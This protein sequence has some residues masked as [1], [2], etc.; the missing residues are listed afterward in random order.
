MKFINDSTGFAIH[1]KFV[2]YKTSDSGKI[3]EKIPRDNQF[4]DAGASHNDL[5][6]INNNQFWAAGYRNFV[7]LN[8]NAGGSTIPK[9]LFKI[10]TIGTGATGI[11]KLN[12][13]SKPNYQY[14][15]YVNNQLLNSNYS[16]TY[17]HN[18]ANPLDSVKLV[19]I[20]GAFKDSVTKYQYFSGLPALPAPV[21]DSFT[22]ASSNKD[23]T[24]TIYGNNFL[25]INTV[26]FGNV[27]ASSFTVISPTIIKAVVGNGN[28]G[29][30]SVSNNSG[31]SSKTGFVYTTRLKITSFTPIS[32]EV[33]TLVFING[34]NFST[35]STNNIVYF[36]AVKAI[37]ESASAIQLAV[38]VPA[39]ISYL[40]INVTVNGSTV[41]SNLPFTITYNAGCTFNEYSFAP[42]L[43][44]AIEDLATKIG[45]GDLDG[46]G[47]QDIVT[48]N[49]NQRLAFRRNTST[50]NGISFA[51]EQFYDISG[52]QTSSGVF[53]I[54][55]MDGDGKLDISVSNGSY[56]YGFNILKNTSVPGTISFAA[57][58]QYGNNLLS[59][60][61]GISTEDFDGDG[62]PEV[63]GHNFARG[64]V[65]KNNNNSGVLG[66]P[67]WPVFLIP[68][69]GGQV[70]TC[71]AAD[72]DGDGKKDVIQNSEY[73]YNNITVFKNKCVDGN[74]VFDAP[75]EFFFT[76]GN[77]NFSKIAV[78]DINNDN[79][80]DVIMLCRNANTF[81]SIRAIKNTSTINSLSFN[82]VVN[83]QIDGY[84]NNI[85]M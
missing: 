59:T 6:F 19:V 81:C 43:D 66:F 41:Y 38:R 39:G 55:D 52:Y 46:D 79:K 25:V 54:T 14:K 68:Y 1:E 78:G 37:V 32:G 29:L 56:P 83:T 33:G 16:T 73:Y 9:T 49:Q 24:V 2:I 69:N 63:F 27:N 5:F 11:V 18:N 28:S 84:P 34:T 10:D 8:T 62:K 53:S 36:G 70:S 7:E 13:F 31:T 50:A 48:G 51:N 21:I 15:W 82:Q 72:M 44:S 77:S 35:T 75:E 4:K 57:L 40:P 12:N 60:P 47:L 80:V 42:R 26:K 61:N 23:F 74:I 64:F 65:F 71:L 30:V 58:Q 20:N 22:P 17:L 76:G 3:W 67:E 85:K 45:T